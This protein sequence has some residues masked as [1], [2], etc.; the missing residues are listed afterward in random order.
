M[1]RHIKL[2][3][4][5]VIL[6]I[7]RKIDHSAISIPFSRLKSFSVFIVLMFENVEKYLTN[8]LTESKNVTKL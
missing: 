2:C 7:Q 3:S 8:K 4:F 5:F 1:L 6:P